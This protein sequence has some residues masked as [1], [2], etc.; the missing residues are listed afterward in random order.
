VLSYQYDS[1][2]ALT[3]M[4]WNGQPLLQGITYNVSVQSA[5]LE[6]GGGS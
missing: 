2:G 6:S 3:G 1:T 4:R 5:H